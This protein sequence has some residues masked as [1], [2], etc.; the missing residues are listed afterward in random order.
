MTFASVRQIDAL[1]A[2]L[3]EAE[4]ELTLAVERSLMSGNLGTASF[5]S[6]QLA[7]IQALL[8]QVRG[9]TV[10]RAVE[11]LR[12]T[13]KEGLKVASLSG[14]SDSSPFSGIHEEAVKV[15]SDSMTQRLDDAFATVGRRVEDVFRKEGLRLSALQLAEGS[16]RVE[17]SASLVDALKRQGIT[18]FQDRAGREWG[19][20]RYSDMVLRT[21]TR[22]ATSEGTRNRLIE[23][24]LDL[25]EWVAAA[26][27]CDRCQEFA[28]KVFSLTGATDGYEVLDELP[29]IHPN[30][31]CVIVPATVTL[32]ELE[33]A[34]A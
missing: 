32:D 29:P 8:Q 20:T 5:Q 28:G 14:L 3:R 25:V 13:Y 12:A 21:T 6:Q 26:D 31:I 7:E 18:A 17:A 16:T 19:L 23:G 22:E 1:V 30:D 27:C 24:G 10:P 9:E 2:I 11:I 15:L 33:K 4:T 34:L